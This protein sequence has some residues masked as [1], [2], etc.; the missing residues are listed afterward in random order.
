MFSTFE[1]TH[2]SVKPLVTIEF[3]SILGKY[4]LTLFLLLARRVFTPYTVGYSFLLLIQDTGRKAG[5][6]LSV[7]KFTVWLTQESPLCHGGM[8]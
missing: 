5:Y 6:N 3:N 8:I 7:R 2:L 4:T 1:L